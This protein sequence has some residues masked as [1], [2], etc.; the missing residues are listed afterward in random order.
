MPKGVYVRRKIRKMRKRKPKG[1][2]APPSPVHRATPWVSVSLRAE[3]YVMLRE[4]GEFYEA[5]LSALVASLVTEQFLKIL[6][7]NNP[8]QAKQLREEL[9]YEKN[10][11]NLVDLDATD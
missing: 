7:L 5:T 4:L 9:G 2:V 8:E 6:E 3:H 11:K 1:Y 10:S